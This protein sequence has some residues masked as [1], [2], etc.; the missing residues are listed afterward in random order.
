M[1]LRVPSYYKNFHCIAEKCEHSCCIGWEIDIDD[2]SFAYYQSVGGAFGKRL[3]E[4]TATENGEHCFILRENTWCPFLNEKKLCDIYSELGEEALCEVCTEYPRFTVEYGN[5]REKAL[6]FSCE[7]VGRMIFSETGKLSYEDVEMPDCWDDGEWGDGGD[8]PFE[9]DM[10]EFCSHLEEYRDRA[11]EILQNREAPLSDRIRDYL[12]FCEGV[13]RVY[14]NPNEGTKTAAEYWQRRMEMFCE[15]EDVN[16]EWRETKERVRAYFQENPYE[17]ALD[18][19]RKS[20][21]YNEIWYEHIMVYFAYRY[22]MR[23]WYDGNLLAKAQFCVLGFLAI[24]DMDIVRYFENGERFTLGDRIAVARIFS[25]EVEHSEETLE[26]L[27]DDISFDGAFHV[28][29]LL[30]QI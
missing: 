15:L 23:A 6:S 11:V 12:R 28:R 21:S 25:R 9:D 27:E 26:L 16:D 29:Q 1:I 14:E 22:L 30:L 7:E 10:A 19:Y 24:R 8:A 13:Q 4:R 17:E 20:A 3:A 2:D 18:A 5:V